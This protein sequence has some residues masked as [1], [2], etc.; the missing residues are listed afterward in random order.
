[1][2]LNHFYVLKNKK[3]IVEKCPFPMFKLNTNV[4]ASLYYFVKKGNS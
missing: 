4:K 1:M 3:I 2:T